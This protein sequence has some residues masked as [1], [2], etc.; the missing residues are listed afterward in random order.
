MIHFVTRCAI[1]AASIARFILLKTHLLDLKGCIPS[2]ALPSRQYMFYSY[3]R[4]K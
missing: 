3:A 4:G 1:A 2:M